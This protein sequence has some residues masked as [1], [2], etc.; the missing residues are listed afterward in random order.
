MGRQQLENVEEDR[1]EKLRVWQ[2]EP[3]TGIAGEEGSQLKDQGDW[4]TV[5]PQ[6]VRKQG[7]AGFK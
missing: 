6:V 7:G 2:Q 1:C 3:V 5:I 4:G